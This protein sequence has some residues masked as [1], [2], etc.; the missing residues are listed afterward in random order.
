[1]W[2]R[3]IEVDYPTFFFIMV[4][5]H[6]LIQKKKIKKLFPKM[7]EHIMQHYFV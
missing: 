2:N 1:M 7:F 4:Y 5:Q 6:L 3:L